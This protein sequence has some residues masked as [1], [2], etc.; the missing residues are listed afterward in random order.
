L[1]AADGTT[2]LHPKRVIA[3]FVTSGSASACGFYHE[4][5]EGRIL[6]AP[7]VLANYRWRMPGG[8]DNA[9]TTAAIAFPS[10]AVNARDRCPRMDLP[11]TR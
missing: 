11:E 7:P 5:A 8:I 3:S 4:R 2:I 10:S 6:G 1:Y 9:W